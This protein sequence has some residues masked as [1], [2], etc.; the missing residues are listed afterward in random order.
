MARIRK[1][2]AA[3]AALEAEAAVEAG[4]LRLRLRLRIRKAEAAVAAVEAEAARGL[5]RA[6]IRRIRIR[7][8]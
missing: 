1:A 4:S 6:R 7:E 5:G 2:E 8:A 3:V